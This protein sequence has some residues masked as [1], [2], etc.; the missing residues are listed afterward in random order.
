MSDSSEQFVLIVI[1]AFSY[2]LVDTADCPLSH[3]WPM[4][5]R[6]TDKPWVI[7]CAHYDGTSFAVEH[8]CDNSY[9]RSPVGHAWPGVF[10]ASLMCHA[11]LDLDEGA[12]T[13]FQSLY[14]VWLGAVFLDRWQSFPLLDRLI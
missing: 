1:P 4:I 13:F 5:L 12:L 11:G 9:D 14:R 7:G 6:L 10:R 3:S 8:G 2:L